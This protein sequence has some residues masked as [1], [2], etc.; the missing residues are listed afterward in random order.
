MLNIVILLMYKLHISFYYK[1][2]R[3]IIDIHFYVICITCKYMKYTARTF[4]YLFITTFYL[5]FFL[6]FS[7]VVF[8]WFGRCVLV[9]L[10]CTQTFSNVQVTALSNYYLT[11]IFSDDLFFF[12]ISLDCLPHWLVRYIVTF[13]LQENHSNK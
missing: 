12:R 7:E 5:F 4:I 8:R 1:K 3:G 6:W 13:H 9:L 2:F 10:V 11:F